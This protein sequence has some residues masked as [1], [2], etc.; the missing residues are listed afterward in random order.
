MMRLCLQQVRPPAYWPELQ[1]GLRWKSRSPEEGVPALPSCGE[2]A[3]Q[4]L[5]KEPQPVPDFGAPYTPEPLT[6]FW[7]QQSSPVSPRSQT[8]VADP[9]PAVKDSTSESWPLGPW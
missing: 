7:F 9:V 5:V 4:C 6:T 2:R 1:V 8:Q 3:V